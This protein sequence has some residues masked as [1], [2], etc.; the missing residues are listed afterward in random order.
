VIS[1]RHETSW[2]KAV[3][4]F[5]QP[6]FFSMFGGSMLT[7]PVIPSFLFWPKPICSDFCRLK[8]R[9]HLYLLA[10]KVRLNHLLF[11]NAT[12]TGRVNF[13]LASGFKVFESPI[14]RAEGDL[15]QR[16]R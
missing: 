13:K 10:A 9:F 1:P 12:V 15:S 6:L 16:M 14:F 4:L 3:E 5:S 11:D 2:L 8:E 7:A